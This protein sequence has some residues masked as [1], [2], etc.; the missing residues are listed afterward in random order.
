[1]ALYDTVFYT[2]SGN[3]STTGYYAVPIWVASA[4]IAPG[5]LVRQAT[6]PAV[7]S[8]RVFIAVQSGTQTTG[9]TE[10]TWVI[11]RGGRTTDGSVI[12]QECTGIAALNG[13]S[14]NCVNWTQAKAIANPTLG[15]VIKRNNGVSLQMCTLGAGTGATEPAFSDTPGVVTTDSAAQWVCLGLPA[16]FGTWAAPHARLTNAITATWGAVGNDFYVADN[17]AEINT[18]STIAL[19]SAATPCR[20]FSVD[21]TAA[22]PPTGSALKPGATITGTST[23]IGIG[24]TTQGEVYLY[25]FNFI[26]SGAGA[27]ALLTIASNQA[28]RARCEACTFQLTGGGATSTISIGTTTSNNGGAADLVNC[29]FAFSNAGQ[30]MFWAG[31]QHTW[32]NSAP[33]F[34]G[35]APTTV[36]RGS[37]GNPGSLLIEGV[38][39]SSLGGNTLVSTTLS[40][41]FLTFK[42]CKLGTGAI[43][44]APTSVACVMNVDVVDCDSGAAIYRN[45]RHNFCG[46]MTTSA[47]IYRN[48]G[49]IDGVTPI[50]HS[51]VGTSFVHTQRPFTSLPLVIWNSLV[52]SVRTVTLYGVIA[53]QTSTPPFNDQFWF[54]VYYQGTA[55]SPIASMVSNGQATLL[56]PHTQVA[57]N[58]TVSVWNGLA[59]SNSPFSLTVTLTA[60]QAG[61]LTIYPKLGAQCTIY[62]DPR[63]VLS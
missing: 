18:G 9:A 25:G 17:S 12:W 27:G 23:G 50:A 51:L 29:S 42:N 58:D 61:Y 15:A 5:T 57:V 53:G 30:V 40:G 45:E 46:D 55:G 26:A 39:L 14:T 32:R 33:G 62:L 52:G 21:H 16:S 8:E 63:P 34:S 28:A 6:T 38:D 56:T 31:G 54:E 1:M 7:G 11:T 37:S 41:A 60:Q 35:T 36:F 3:G 49:A 20:Y 13:D 48:G 19:G 59:G 24:S 43:V 4:S 10:P 2:H 44:S 47:T 22:L